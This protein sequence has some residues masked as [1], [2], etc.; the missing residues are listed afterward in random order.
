MNL[1]PFGSYRTDGYF[2]LTL[3]NI[4]NIANWIRVFPQPPHYTC[5]AFNGS[6]AS[7]V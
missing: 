5:L 4:T 3:Y 2:H 7:V 1:H 6:A